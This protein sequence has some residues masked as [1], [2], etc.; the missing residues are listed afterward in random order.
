MS[1]ENRILG[2][3][4]RPGKVISTTLLL[5][6]FCV[7]TD[8]NANTQDNSNQLVLQQRD[9]DAHDWHV[10]EPK[11]LVFQGNPISMENPGGDPD[12]LVDG[13]RVYVYTSTDA[14]QKVYLTAGDPDSDGIINDTYHDMDGYTVWSSEDMVHWVNHGVQFTAANMNP[15][16]WASASN[17]NLHMTV[18]TTL[19]AASPHAMWA[20]SAAKYTNGTD[21]TYVLYYPKGIDG[22]SM[23]AT[24]YAT[25]PTPAGP[26]TD[27]G[28]IYGDI[29]DQRYVIGMDP[30]VFQDEDGKIYIYGNGATGSNPDAPGQVVVAELSAFDHATQTQS[31]ITVP[32]TINYDVNNTMYDGLAGDRI[33]DTDF[34]EGGSMHK[35][36]GKYYLS[37]AEH[38]HKHYNGWYSMCETPVGPCEWMGPTIKGIYYGNQHGSFVNFKGR[39]YFLTH[40]D[41]FKEVKERYDWDSYRRTWTIYPVTYNADKSIRVMYPEASGFNVPSINIGGAFTDSAGVKYVDSSYISSGGYASVD[42]AGLDALRTANPGLD[43]LQLYKAQ[44]ISWDGPITVSVPVETGN[45]SV[46]LKFSENFSQADEAWFKR[47]MD[48]RAEGSTVKEGLNVYEMAGLY[49]AHQEAFSVDVKDG[50][51]NIDISASSDIPML[52]A[53]KIEKQSNV[54][55]AS[56]LGGPAT[57]VNSVAYSADPRVG[58]FNDN[59][60]EKI[61]VNPSEVLGATQQEEVLFQTSRIG[62]SG[63]KYSNASLG[64]GEYEVT[65]GFVETHHNAPNSRVFDVNIEGVNVLENFDIFKSAGGKNL[66][67]KRVF[68]VS[69]TDGV[70]NI[71]LSTKVDASKISFIKV[72]KLPN[73][74]LDTSIRIDAGQTWGDTDTAGAYFFKDN[75][76]LVGVST[77][78]WYD[79]QPSRNDRTYSGFAESIPTDTAVYQTE[80][81]GYE[82]GYAIPVR[83][84]RYTVRLMFAELYHSAAGKREFGVTLEGQDLEVTPGNTRFDIYKIAGGKNKGVDFF[85]DTDVSDG[86]LNIDFNAIKDKASVV[87]IVV[88]P[89]YL[90]E[91]A[92]SSDPN[93]WEAGYR[94]DQL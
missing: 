93:K 49:G 41:H 20:P 88:T 67:L 10:G 28:P 12:F 40:Q 69:L 60:D 54:A 56:N 94:D 61:I 16:K 36:N 2:N 81:W 65:L 82:F 83:N 5:A 39:D 6:L 29:G 72:T 34:H 87:G 64:N 9:I 35:A 14:N 1:I 21:T 66:A 25:A 74:A 79:I 7:A 37:W 62:W 84:G 23:F 27:Q 50:V 26:F 11:K 48:I 75:Q 24:G 30:N 33:P 92:E 78:S 73:R 19:Q 91:N 59:T 55:W 58:D 86:A 53:V 45:Y 85:F 57:T 31:V 80:R 90:K 42:A 38:L 18:N 89:Y 22:T 17:T 52:S 63:L 76:F 15:A 70:L 71:D 43:D 32:Q 44:R 77:D 13:D 47:V 3:D 8:S 51:L 46:T 4:S 68:P